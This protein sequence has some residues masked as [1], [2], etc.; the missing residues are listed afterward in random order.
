MK[1]KE[2]KGKEIKKKI[3]EKEGAGDDREKYHAG[4]R[5]RS[6]FSKGNYFLKVFTQ[7]N[8]Y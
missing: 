2:N 7:G 3:S 5:R 8:P 4:E 1:D 6:K